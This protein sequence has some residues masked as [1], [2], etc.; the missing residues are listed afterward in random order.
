ML[1]TARA[2]QTAGHR[3]R[4][5]PAPPWPRPTPLGAPRKTW[6]FK[7]QVS[8]LAGVAT[9]KSK[10]KLAVARC[11]GRRWAVARASR[12]P[13]DRPADLADPADPQSVTLQEETRRCHG[14][15]ATEDR[16][17]QL[18]FLL[19]RLS[20]SFNQQNATQHGAVRAVAVRWV[21]N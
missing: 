14:N 11:G 12:E 5:D 19:I 13:Q 15:D 6:C 2:P 21:F 7:I 1:S 16:K 17:S 8:R 3:P 9:K 10:Q 18:L 4:P 20:R